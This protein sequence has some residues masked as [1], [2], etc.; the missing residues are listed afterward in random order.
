M[1]TVFVHQA[2]STRQADRIDPAWL[3]VESGAIVWVDLAKPTDPEGRLL[4]DLFH[5][6]ELSIQDALSTVHHP[7]VESYDGYL[8][9]ILHGIDFQAS[10]HKF[11]THDTDFFLG[12]NYLVTVHDGTTRTIGE[13][14]ALGAQNARVLGEG[15]TAL[16]HR[17][18]DTM[19]THYRPEVDKLEHRL[20]MLEDRVISD[21]GGS[22]MR[23]ILQLKRDVASLRRITLPQ[24][25]AVGRLA[26][27]EFRLIDTEMSYRFRD[28]YDQLVRL[29]DDG[30]VFQDRITAILDA[31]LTTVSN[32]LNQVM[33]V[34]TVIATIFMPMTVMTGLFGMN[35]VL[36]RLPGGDASQFWWLTGAMV[37][38]AAAMLAWFSRSGW[39]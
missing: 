17:L 6:H 25:D 18:V 21:R 31:H 29:V 4:S 15:S 13:I 19:V 9:L 34:L 39:L 27:R 1:I 32:R 14:Q 10:R 2:G 30:L 38:L 16:L 5:F 24:R 3:G 23:Q 26:R 11:A 37:A 7:K 28:V 12:P 20:D 8:Y 22:F 35:M 36:P 33:K